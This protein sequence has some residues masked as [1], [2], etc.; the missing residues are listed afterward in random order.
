[1]DGSN[2]TSS[3]V[4]RAP[5]VESV[6]T[7]CFSVNAPPK[8]RSAN[9]SADTGAANTRHTQAATSISSNFVRSSPAMADLTRLASMG[10]LLRSLRA[11]PVPS[12]T[13]RLRRVLHRAGEIGRAHV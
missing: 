9:H 2:V 7:S 10:F 3:V 11:Y 8:Y 13:E 5:A 1:M 6:S 12:P 4:T